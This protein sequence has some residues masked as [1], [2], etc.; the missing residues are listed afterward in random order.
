MALS[1]AIIAAAF[2]VYSCFFMLAWQTA[3]CHNAVFDFYVN[4]FG[5]GWILVLI[6]YLLETRRRG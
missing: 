4:I 6:A 2:V 1:A 5:F 3:S